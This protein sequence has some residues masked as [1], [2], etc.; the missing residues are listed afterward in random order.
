MSRPVQTV[1]FL[2][3]HGESEANVAE[4]ICGDSESPLTKR[5][6]A[7]TVEVAERL[8]GVKFD[9]AYTSPL[10]RAF[11]TCEAILAGRGVTATVL[12]DLREQDFG[13]WEGLS[14]RELAEKD[15]EAIRRFTNDPMNATGEGG[16]TL[17]VFGERVRRAIFDD[18]LANHAGETVLVVSHGGT[19]R[20]ALNLLLDLDLSRHFFRFDIQNATAA[21]VR[22]S[23]S[24]ARLVGLN[25]REMAHLR[26]RPRG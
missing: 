6:V 12:P 22:H 15:P 1:I 3:R 17:G 21:V 23:D 8:A 5:G 26:L 13:A 20:V 19:T 16:E 4:V 11:K 10:E 24:G 7:Q 18:V 25:L 9:A 2:V 14:F